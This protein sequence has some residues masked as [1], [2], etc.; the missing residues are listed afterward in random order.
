[1]LTVLQWVIHSDP[2]HRTI[3]TVVFAVAA[4]I[5]VCAIIPH[6]SLPPPAAV[7][8]APT[9]HPVAREAQA[10]VDSSK[11]LSQVQGGKVPMYAQ[12]AVRVVHDCFVGFTAAQCF[13]MIQAT[14]PKT[15]PV[16]RVNAKLVG[17]TPAPTPTP[18]VFSQEQIATMYDVARAADTSVLSDP[19]T[20]IKVDAT[21]AQEEVPT[22]RLFAMLTPAGSGIGLDVV[23]RKRFALVAG[24]IERG[25]R[26]APV[27]GIHWEVPR[28]SLS[29]G[30]VAYYDRNVHAQISCGT[31][32]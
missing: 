19:N 22:S 31:H 21:L 13:A 12:A 4:V 28:T 23:R 5:V 15:A 10:A 7:A 16:L 29:C 3:R 6:P 25:A 27:L 11:M 8:H 14:R 18:G 17:P 32:F 24:A 2:L 9:P 20:K 1:M 26:I 30:P